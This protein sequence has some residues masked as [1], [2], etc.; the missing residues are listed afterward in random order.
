MPSSP[1]VAAFDLDGTL[2]EGGS[3]FHWLRFLAGDL[4]VLRA[5]VPLSVPLTI[6]ALRSGHW[7]D[8][9]KERLF[10]SVLAG[11]SL[12]DVT[13]ASRTFIL[14]HLAHEGRALVIG[15]LRWHLDQGHDVVLVSASPQ[16]YVDILVQEFGITGGLGTRLSVDA[17]GNLTGSY[18]GKNCRGTEKMRRLNE[19]IA[20]RHYEVAPD[21][22]AYGN[23]RGDRRLLAGASHP[24]DCGKLGRFGALRQYPRLTASEG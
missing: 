12:T 24:F 8:D 2:T 13:A 11:R 4:A 3:V 5:A 21:I 15:R 7:A 18:E 23:S 19:W 10:R 16:I 14:D 9:A 6:G 20:A 22:Y 1:T 17:A